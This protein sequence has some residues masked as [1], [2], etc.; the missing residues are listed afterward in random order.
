LKT[1]IINGSPRVNGDTAALVRELRAH[2]SGEV[3]EL[4]AYRA[5][6]SPC[7]DCRACARVKGCAIDDDMRAIYGDDFDNA[8]IASP[9]YY[10]TLPGQMMN[11]ASRFQVQRNAKYELND[12]FVL[13]PKR[14]GLILVGGGKGNENGAVRMS[15]VLFRMMNASGFG[16][17]TVLSMNTD[18]VPAAEDE[19]ALEGVR[20]LA[21]WLNGG[22]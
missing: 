15:A 22:E 18:T 2:L 7:V 20:S 4:S 10:S 9:V 13:R 5:K 8:V 11:I 1:L 12:P 14:A 19:T 3:A 6:L 17:H 21:V 16:A